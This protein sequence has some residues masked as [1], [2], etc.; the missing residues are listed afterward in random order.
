MS[1]QEKQQLWLLVMEVANRARSELYFIERSQGEM[2]FERVIGEV[3][4]FLK[5][6][7]AEKERSKKQKRNRRV[8]AGAS[9][10]CS[11]YM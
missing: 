10:A 7:A 2:S 6:K 4:T 3:G 5:G 1:R 9:L 11:G 8:G